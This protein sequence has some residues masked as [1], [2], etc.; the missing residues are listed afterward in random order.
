M[1]QVDQEETVEM[2]ESTSCGNAEIR[3]YSM[4]GI[5]D[6]GVTIKLVQ[7]IEP[8]SRGELI[9]YENGPNQSIKLCAAIP[10]DRIEVQDDTLLVNGKVLA[11]TEGAPLFLMNQGQID[12]W[13]EWATA[14]NNVVPKDHYFLVGNNNTAIDSRQKGL[15]GIH[16]FIAKAVHG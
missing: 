14:I 5:L 8:V 10:G 16:Q 6:P 12:C 1:H 9:V 3:G 7:P 15:Y 2:A 13:N 11:N 4:F